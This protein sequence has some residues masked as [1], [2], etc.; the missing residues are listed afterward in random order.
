MLYF[1]RASEVQDHGTGLSLISDEESH[2]PCRRASE[3]CHHHGPPARMKGDK[4][5]KGTGGP[6]DEP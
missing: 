4:K 6:T 2:S 1:P 5:V 3:I